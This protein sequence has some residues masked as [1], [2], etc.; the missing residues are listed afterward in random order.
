MPFNM[1]IRSPRTAAVTLSRA[2]HALTNDV[3]LWAVIR[4]SCKEMSFAKY[5]LFMDDVMGVGGFGDLERGKTSSDSLANPKL[6]E[7]VLTEYRT[8][9]QELARARPLPF[10]GADRYALLKAATEVYVM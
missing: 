10:T 6:D 2:S 3:A 8:N 9:T 7:H 5:K 4:Y 1:S